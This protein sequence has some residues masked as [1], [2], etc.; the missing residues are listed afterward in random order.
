VHERQVEEAAQGGLDLPVKALLD[1]PV[2]RV[3]RRRIGAVGPPRAA[4]HVAGKLVEQEHEGERAVGRQL[5][6][7]EVAAGCG[8]VGEEEALAAGG[9]ERL[10]R[11]EPAVRPGIPPE[12]DDLVWGCEAVHPVPFRFCRSS[13]FK[14]NS[15]ACHT[16]GWR[17]GGQ[18]IVRR[19]DAH[20][21]P[22]FKPK[23]VLSG[24]T[25]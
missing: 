12:G 15:A 18:T 23:R 8:L 9:V 11:L 7:V 13:S 22:R 2:G 3:N 25:P 20:L 6:F 21:P 1:R 16:A 19:L 14:Q 24:G 10:V 5:P 17:G 4:E